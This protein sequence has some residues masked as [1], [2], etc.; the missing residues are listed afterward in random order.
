MYLGKLNS[1]TGDILL[2]ILLHE[3]WV[4]FDVLSFLSMN[5][6]ENLSKYGKLVY[7]CTSTCL[8]MFGTNVSCFLLQTRRCHNVLYHL[9][10][11][12]GFLA[13]SCSS[14]LQDHRLMCFQS[15]ENN[16]TTS[17]NM[18]YSFSWLVMYIS[19][20]LSQE[21]VTSWLIFLE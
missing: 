5:S 3:L 7:F 1:S 20:G 8:L 14:H 16:L 4:W 19:H 11:P 21:L 9:L 6:F 18:F 10:G 17:G 12:H 15:L 13:I 2:L